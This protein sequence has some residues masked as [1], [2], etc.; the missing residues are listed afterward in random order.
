MCSPDPGKVC[1]EAGKNVP[2]VSLMSEK[3]NRLGLLGCNN[4]INLSSVVI[5][6]SISFIFPTFECLRT[7]K[8]F[9]H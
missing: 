1:S 8:I 6:E 2:D 7:Q 9:Q 3:Q 5:L 4:A